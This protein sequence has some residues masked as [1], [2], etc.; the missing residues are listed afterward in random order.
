MRKRKKYIIEYCMPKAELADWKQWKTWRKY[1]TKK[2][3]DK[4]FN[5]LKDKMKHE[6]KAFDFRKVDK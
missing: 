1:T 6:I 4:V 5:I 3:R 2:D